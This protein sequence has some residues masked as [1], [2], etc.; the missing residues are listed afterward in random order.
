MENYQTFIP[1]MWYH[2]LRPW[3]VTEGGCL[4]EVPTVRPWTNKSLVFC[5]LS[6][7]L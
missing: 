6:A 7:H 5:L 4:L 1:K 2:K 3:S